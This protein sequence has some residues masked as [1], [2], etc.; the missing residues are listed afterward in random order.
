MAEINSGYVVIDNTWFWRADHDVSGSVYASRNPVDTGFIV[1]GDNVTAY[2]LAVEH[3]LGEMTVWNGNYG[4]TYFYQSELPYDVDSD[5]Q[6]KGY[7]GY[8]VADSVTHHE[9]YG[10]GV[11][12]YFRDHDVTANS[13]IKAPN[14][15]GVQFTDSISVF[16]SGNGGIAHIINDEGNSV[17]NGNQNEW[18]C[19]YNNSSFA[20]THEL[21][22]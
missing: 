11:Y 15:P 8:T 1:N 20:V 22:L 3:V 19:N 12:S 21:F 18:Q 10:I 6:S 2:G 4:K 7:A 16:L 9:G 14:V 13:A 5:W 17:H